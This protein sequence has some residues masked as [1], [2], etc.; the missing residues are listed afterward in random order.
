MQLI[1]LDWSSNN[2]IMQEEIGKPVN[3]FTEH[4]NQHKV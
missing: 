1:K 3:Q 2:K 4:I